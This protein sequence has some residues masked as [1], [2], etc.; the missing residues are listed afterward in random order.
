MSLEA[1]RIGTLFPHLA[2]WCLLLLFV[3]A[4]PTGQAAAAASPLAPSTQSGQTPATAPARANAS[5]NP[6]WSQ[7]NPDQQTILAPLSG[8]WNGLS[9]PRKQKWIQI[10]QRYKTMQP[11]DQQRLQSQMRD[12]ARLTPEERRTA[13]ENYRKIEHLPKEKKQERWAAYQQLPPEKKQQLKK[14]PVSAKKPVA[15]PAGNI[16]K[17]SASV[18]VLQTRKK[19]PKH[20]AI[21]S[22]HRD[23]EAASA[24]PPAAKVKAADAGGKDNGSTAP[25]R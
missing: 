18:P 19:V 10:A 12:W 15:P 21:Q 23:A 13:R 4:V 3:I 22:T 5:S 16:S 25:S 17:S 24:V 2:Q 1:R 6:N 9:A 14:P 11:E 7:L 8:E 20:A